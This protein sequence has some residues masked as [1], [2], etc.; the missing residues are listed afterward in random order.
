MHNPHTCGQHS[1]CST[2][3][4]GATVKVPWC[5]CCC[6]LGH[7]R[8]PLIEG[9]PCHLQGAGHCHKSKETEDF[10][11]IFVEDAQDGELE[12]LSLCPAHLS[13]Q[14]HSAGGYLLPG[15]I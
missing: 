10:V 6:S 14:E 15:P 8:G 12:V 9:S 2:G 11:V 5:C 3:C 7:S 4:R 13:A 1:P